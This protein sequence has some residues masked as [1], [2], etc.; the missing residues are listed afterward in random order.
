MDKIQGMYKNQSTIPREI[1]I[2]LIIFQTKLG[3]IIHLNFKVMTVVKKNILTDGVSGKVG[4]NLVF[5]QSNGKTIVSS[6]PTPS[7]TQT[8]AG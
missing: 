6:R 1:S 4:R 5:S 8:E 2:L 7:E 3:F